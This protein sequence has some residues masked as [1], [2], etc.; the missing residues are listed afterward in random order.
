[1][2]STTRELGL[3][4]VRNLTGWLAAGSLAAAVFFGVA[5]ASSHP[6]KTVKSSSGTS[7]GSGSDSG[8]GLGATSGEDG[9]GGDDGS[10]SSGATGASGGT[11]TGVG[12]PSSSAGS[13][14]VSSGAS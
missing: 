2:A 4:Q 9:G 14:V 10:G 13:P 7:L 12:L 6:A 5:A 1:M 3:R 11:G 8:A